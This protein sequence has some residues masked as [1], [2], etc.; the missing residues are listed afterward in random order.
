MSC[1]LNT[2]PV[3]LDAPKA[4]FTFSECFKSIDVRLVALEFAS[5]TPGEVSPDR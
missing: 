4:A 2:V 5:D 3:D 1:S